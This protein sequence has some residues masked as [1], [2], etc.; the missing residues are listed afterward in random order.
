[1]KVRGK[2]N[3]SKRKSLSLQHKITKKATEKGRKQRKEARRLRKTGVC[4]HTKR[5][6]A[7]AIEIP[8]KW[9][10]KREELLLQKE[11]QERREL[12]HKK[13]L[14]QQKNQRRLEKKKSGLSEKKDEK[15][16]ANAKSMSIAGIRSNLGIGGARPEF[17]L[18]TAVNSQTD[19]VIEVVDARD[20]PA[21][22]I[23]N[24]ET[25]PAFEN[26][27]R[28]VVVTRGDQVPRKNLD[29]WLVKL[30]EEHG[31]FNVPVIPL[32][33]RSHAEEADENS[34]HARKLLKSAANLAEEMGGSENGTNNTSDVKLNFIRKKPL[35]PLG[36][37]SLKAILNQ[38]VGKKVENKLLDKTQEEE[39]DFSHIKQVAVIGYPKTGKNTVA[40]YLKSPAL[41]FQHKKMKILPASLFSNVEEVEVKASKVTTP[42]DEPSELFQDL[43]LAS[44]YP[45]SVRSPL[46]PLKRLLERATS[47]RELQMKLCLPG[48]DQATDLLKTVMKNRNLGGAND[49]A[50]YLVKQWKELRYYTELV[51]GPSEVPKSNSS[52]SSS[53]SEFSK[54]YASASAD[55]DSVVNVQVNNKTVSTTAAETW[56][57][58]ALPQ[59][60]YV[61]GKS[62]LVAAQ[63]SLIGVT[64]GISGANNPRDQIKMDVDFNANSSST[65]SLVTVDAGM[66]SPLTYFAMRS[67]TTT[68]LRN[69]PVPACL[70]EEAIKETTMSETKSNL[71]VKDS[72]DEAMSV[73][74]DSEEEEEEEGDSEDSDVEM[75]EE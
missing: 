61:I 32:I 25:L 65:N 28:I 55:L 7:K 38:T 19:L 64:N 26:K 48:F 62:Q 66:I 51:G 63:R 45:Q 44:P 14:E 29:A 8:S 33:K 3:N 46:F 22:S 67:T 40:N 30:R 10:F 50:R 36:F 17:E 71:V 23:K 52:S 20:P 75:E 57:A 24:S 5:K 68:S 70:R 31:R 1:M 4:L 35:K 41:N 53:D 49:A 2:K 56:G 42:G 72:D 54:A 11:R 16:S 43:L 47:K 69:G 59:Y 37:E 39:F 6:K 58:S 21:T 73:G 13:H 34:K 18:R 9:P 74:D 12:D 27:K 60:G 15:D